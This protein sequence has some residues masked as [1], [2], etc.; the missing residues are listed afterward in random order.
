MPRVLGMMAGTKA[1]TTAGMTVRNMTVGA[2]TITAL[3]LAVPGAGEPRRYQ[4]DAGQ[5]QVRVQVGRAGLLKMAGHNH[6]VAAPR[7]T[8]EIVA[9]ESELARS[10]VSLDFEA[11]ALAVLPEDEPEG[12]APKVEAAMRGEKLL[13][14]ARF[15]KI[16]FR[17]ET[18][19]G[20]AGSPGVWD[21]EVSGQMTIHGVSRRMTLPVHVEREG[22]GLVA[23]GRATLRHDE[24]GLTPISVAGVVKVKN[25]IEVTYRFVARAAP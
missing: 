22:A 25:E 23:S 5:S 12:D 7:V 20:K 9:D 1:G 17:S 2:A 21:L 16:T 13:D 19:G 24:F 6:I 3:A 18:V 4:V 8:G 10:T 11:A 15:P 14:V